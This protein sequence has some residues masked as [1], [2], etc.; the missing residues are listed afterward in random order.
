MSLPATVLISARRPVAGLL[1]AL[2]AIAA[3]HQ[4]PLLIEA[5]VV[6][7]TAE[8]LVGIGHRCRQLGAALAAGTVYAIGRMFYK[9]DGYLSLLPAAANCGQV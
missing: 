7:G 3:T 1:G 9:Q 2:S 4:A 6:V 5:G 8:R